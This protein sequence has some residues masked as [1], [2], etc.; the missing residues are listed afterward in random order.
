[1][2][3]S[4]ILGIGVAFKAG[5]DDL[6]ESPSLGVLDRLAKQGAIVTY[7]DPFVPE[8]VIGEGPIRSSPLDEATVAEQDCV[9]VLTAHDGI[10]FPAVIRV[11]PLVF[12][13][14]GITSGLDAPNVVRL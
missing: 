10:D 5:V 4:R 1:V 3:G 13:T 7:H 8:V 9:I 2:K 12:D 14:R 11:A 6:R